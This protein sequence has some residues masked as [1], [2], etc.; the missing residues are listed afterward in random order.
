M[1]RVCVVTPVFPPEPVVSARTSADIAAALAGNAHT[2]HVLTAF[3]NRP[4]GRLYLGYRRR[5]YLRE[6]ASGGMRVVRCF[7]FLSPE[8]RLV[9]RLLENISFGIT[10][11]VALLCGPRP[12]VIYANT[13]PIFA[14]GMTTLAAKLRRVPLVISVQDI[15]PES[16][17]SQG[18]LRP[19]SR[20]AAIMRRI[21]S[22]IARNAA[23]VI[24]ISERFAQLYRQDRRVPADRVHIVPNWGDT[25]E[26]ASAEEGRALRDETGLPPDDF[27]IVYGGNVGAA[28]GV[29]GVIEALGMAP[30]DARPHLLIAGAGSQLEACRELARTIDPARIKF[31]SPWPAE[32]TGAVFAA[33]DL[34]VLPTHGEQSLASVP[35]KLI[36]YLLAGRPVLA[37]ALPESDTA[38]MIREAGCGWVVAPDQPAELARAITQVR[39]LSAQER[40]DRGEAGRCYALQHLTRE[41]LLP[42]VITILEQAA[43]RQ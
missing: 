6:N 33:A 3:P 22:R 20:L 14:A 8:S 4:A 19:A 27:I 5:L 13:W 9:S 39:A 41:T 16:L 36:S 21:D 17:L 42:R 40:R 35:S 32:K 30:H 24:V 10:S 31:F 29:A 7:S 34:L 18:R 25:T 37:Q 15:Y 23:A 12:H 11:S 1:M 26:P 28:A 43:T 38:R 2:V